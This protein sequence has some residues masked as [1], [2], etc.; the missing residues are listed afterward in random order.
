V[1]GDRGG[2]LGGGFFHADVRVLS[3][4]TV[5]TDGGELVPIQADPDG[6]LFRAVVRGAGQHDPAPGVVLTRHRDLRPGELIE[7]LVLRNSGRHGVRLPL[8]IAA[9]TDLATTQQ[10]NLSLDLPEIEPVG[11]VWRDSTRVVRLAAEPPPAHVGNGVLRYDVELS[12]GQSFECE[13]R[14]SISGPSLFES[15]ELPEVRLVVESADSRLDRLVRQSMT[16][17]RS[18]LLRDPAGIFMAAGAPWFLT[19]FGRDSLWTARMLLPVS[20][21]LAA[22]TLRV[23]AARQGTKVDPDTEEEPGKIMHELRPGELPLGGGRSLPPQYYGTIDAT[24][25]WILLLHDAWRWGLPADAVRELLPALRAAGGWLLSKEGFV[26]YVDRS[27]HGLSNQG[28]KDSGDAVQFADGRLAEPPIA[29]CEVQGYAYEAARAA[30]TLLRAFDPDGPAEQLDDWADRLQA[31]FRSTFWVSDA[32]GAFPAIALDGAGRPVDTVTSNIGHLLGTGLLDA[33]E[34][35]LVA[36]RLTELDSG[37][38]LRTMSPAA[39]G[40]NPLG[41]HTGSVWP[42][43]T[44]IVAFGLRRAGFDPGPLA[45]GIVAAA[46]RFDFRL[47]ELYG[48]QSDSPSPYPAACRP[49]A[50]SAAAAVLLLR[51]LL[52]LEADV[53]N[54]VVRIGPRGL[55]VRMRIDGLRVAGQPFPINIGSGESPAYARL[56]GLD[57]LTENG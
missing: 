27:G 35:A 16:D 13:L 55:P 54:G 45:R 24:P 48:G 17:L 15:A 29:L 30:A 11:L 26:R 19:L 56:D 38:G 21:D 28:W 1:L 39:A 40:F 10:V 33:A 51:A 2:D 50:W 42:H 32:A 8:E 9:G 34:S 25:L 23:L 44:A 4:L 22:G 46:E 37:F 57:M 6:R 7:R 47:P 49:Q 3:R 52:G 18:L 31:A 36:E 12:P 5:Q 20:T 41:Y 43:D 53:P 14:C